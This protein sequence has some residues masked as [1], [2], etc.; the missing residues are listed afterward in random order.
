MKKI[1]TMVMFVLF[2]CAM[3]YVLINLFGGHVFPNLDLQNGGSFGNAK[4]IMLVP[5]LTIAAP[6]ALWWAIKVITKKK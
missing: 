4:R 1:L 2:T 3:G 5:I 6:M